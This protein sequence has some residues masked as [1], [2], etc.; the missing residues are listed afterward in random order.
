M[1]AMQV[2]YFLIQ[3]KLL[4][5]HLSIVKKCKESAILCVIPMLTQKGTE[6]YQ[7]KLE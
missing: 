7:L 3:T 2:F 4:V 5:S 6:D 1:I